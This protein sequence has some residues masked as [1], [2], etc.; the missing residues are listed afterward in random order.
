MVLLALLLGVTAQD[1]DYFPLEKGNEWTYVFSNG[2][3][4]T[5]RVT[6]VATIKGVECA[7]VDTERG[8][9]K[10]REWL[11]V[12]PD[13][14]KSFKMENP[15]G[16]T[17]F[18]Q[19]LLR[20]KFP[21]TKGDTWSLTLQEGPALNTYRYSCDGTETVTIAGKPVEA[22]KITTTLQ[23]PQGPA[24]AS[25][26]YGKGVG[27]VRQLYSMGQQT[28]TAELTKTTLKPP[29]PAPAPAPS[30]AAGAPDVVRYESKDGKV[31][32]YHPKGWT[33]ADG[34]LYGEGTYGVNIQS[35][36]ENAGV[37]FIT[38]ALSEQL[39]DSVALA[40]L[41]L[42]HLSRSN[43]TFNVADMSSTQDRA[44]TTT[45]VTMT[46]GGK[47]LAGHLYF[48]HTKRVGTV[49]AL[50]A[51]EDLLPGMKATLTSIV[52]NLAYAPEGVTT[53]L[54]QGREQAAQTPKPAD[55]KALHPVAVLKDALA[56]GG[57]P[58]D[59]V[60]VTAQDGSFTMSVPKG[61]AFEGAGLGWITTSDARS[62]QGACSVWHT[63]Y[64]P[65]STLAPYVKNA[66]VNPFLPPSQAMVYVT[67]AQ[68]SAR[69]LRVLSACPETDL[70]P[71]ANDAWA[72]A[73]A[74][75]SQIDN[76]ILLVEFEN[77]ATGQPCR[78]IF[79][80]T[81]IS[82]PMGISWSCAIAG[83]WAP[84]GDFDGLVPTLA[85]V[86]SSPRQNEQWV[87]GKF[88]SQA[89]ESKRLNN[90]LMTSLKDLSKSYD[91]YNQSWWDRQ[92][93]QDYT[94]WAFSQTT[95]GQGSW[96]SEREGAEVVRSSSWG[97]ENRQTGE[98]TGAVNHTNFTGRNPWTGEQL[99]EVNT[100]ADYE[101]YIRGR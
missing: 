64:L 65:G 75:G 73:R 29:A 88:A 20:A 8:P 58:L 70:D 45:A 46:Q 35:P 11:A 9:L 68:N 37:L 14:L 13:G 21:L 92:K 32:L 76:R 56:K 78:G 33:V 47:K 93:S 39:P 50:L 12:T 52:A 17:E 96:V 71:A 1:A 6:G 55:G 60:P 23:T 51:R 30:P 94:S 83:S 85:A 15:Y 97:L 66:L 40:N 27:V 57:K 81:C 91:R 84:T 54:Q 59:L 95:L 24:R 25:I 99:N 36:D 10:S 18:P 19:P 90:N 80:V 31:L 38:F 67:R 79:T 3:T 2:Q 5:M 63:V 28:L 53:V 77:V 98:Q 26:W 16:A 86:H 69:N 101:K 62:L 22:L 34:A 87:Q 100:R 72:Q 48:F 61:W 42:G 74:Q 7:G 41:L 44:R 4:M 43:P 49:Y 89:A 82:Y